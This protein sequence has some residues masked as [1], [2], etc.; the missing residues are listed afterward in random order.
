MNKIYI[1]DNAE[2]MFGNC[3]L[4]SEL[5][6]K[7]KNK[8]ED[9]DV[10]FIDINLKFNGSKRIQQTGI[11]LLIWLRLKGLMNHCVLHSFETIHSILNRQPKHLIVTSRGTSFIQQPAVLE[12]VDTSELE[13]EIANR[14]NL[15]LLLKSSFGIDELRH[16]EA[17]LWGIKCLW[18]AHKLIDSSFI[19][20]YPDRIKSKES[21][22][23]NAV[24]P[25]IYFNENYA[26]GFPNVAIVD[27]M[28]RQ[29]SELQGI[30]RLPN[31]ILIDDQAKDGWSKI[32]SKII[33]GDKEEELINHHYN[34]IIPGKLD[35][36]KSVFSSFSKV[37]F[38]NLK[39]DNFIDLVIM[40]LRLFDEVGIRKDLFNLSGIELFKKIRSKHRNIPI[41]IITASNKINVFAH[42]Y[43]LKD[44]D[45]PN[46]FWIK[47][48][49]D[50]HNYE[51]DKLHNY[52]LLATQINTLIKKR[53]RDK[54]VRAIKPGTFAN[55]QNRIRELEVVNNGFPEINEEIANIEFDAATNDKFNQTYCVIDTNIFIKSNL[56]D[57]FDYSQSIILL[58]ALRN[59]SKYGKIGVHI[60]VFAEILKFGMAANDDLINLVARKSHK[61][62]QHLYSKKELEIIIPNAY[63][64]NSEK[65]EVV[66]TGLKPYADDALFNKCKA[67]L[68]SNKT[69]I[70]IS[71]DKKDDGT[72]KQLER[73]LSTKPGLKKLCKIIGGKEMVSDFRSYL[74][75]MISP[76]SV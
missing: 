42:L 10:L 52:L 29:V 40:D 39:K 25:T 21:L 20:D 1:N 62:L 24:A 63:L 5:A 34:V 37:V 26:K 56:D 38:E 11:E 59:H 55:D 27:K 74:D 48:G 32:F 41:L 17:N 16:N 9:D 45:S 35:T 73:F 75:S 44:M 23:S 66:I 61:N 72:A 19:E 33:Y 57:L 70:F 53:R 50:F 71:D 7:I 76:N 6:E 4:L 28:K 8:T 60:N 51:N 65:L 47:E 12:N 69:L 58:S 68:E 13:K 30:V 49:I 2:S 54:F 46:G 15:R 18:D 14:S 64:T 3:A 22:I 43:E 67:L 36:V 31:I